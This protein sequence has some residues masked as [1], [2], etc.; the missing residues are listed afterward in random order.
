MRWQGVR[1]GVAENSDRPEESTLLPHS[2]PWWG[3]EGNMAAGGSGR[4]HT[5]GERERSVHDSCSVYPSVS[6]IVIGLS[7]P[8]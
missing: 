2:P 5:L 4:A 7:L 1:L 3:G 6:M 8:Y